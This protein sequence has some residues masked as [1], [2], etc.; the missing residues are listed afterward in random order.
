MNHDHTP[1]PWHAHTIDTINDQ[2]ALWQIRDQTRGVIATVESV[3][4]SDA[5]LIAAAPALLAALNWFIS[6]LADDAVIDMSKLINEME[7][8]ARAAIRQA[9]E[10]P[11]DQTVE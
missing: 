8:R 7:T 5:Q 11:A 2:P 10:L 9:T 1:A 6:E 3:N 4:R